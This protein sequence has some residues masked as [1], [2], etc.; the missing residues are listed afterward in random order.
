MMERNGIQ[1][2]YY[3]NH[4]HEMNNNLEQQKMKQ[5]PNYVCF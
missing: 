3:L 4:Q 1:E 2:N 5:N